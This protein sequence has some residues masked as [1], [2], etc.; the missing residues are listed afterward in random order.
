MR[1]SLSA[2]VVSAVAA[3]TVTLAQDQFLRALDRGERRLNEGELKEKKPGFVC[4][5]LQ[6][7]ALNSLTKVAIVVQIISKVRI[8]TE[9]TMP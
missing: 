1:S 8:R 6:S 9:V 3:A 4:E 7:K 2:A 5:T